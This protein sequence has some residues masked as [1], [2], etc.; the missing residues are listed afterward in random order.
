MLQTEYEVPDTAPCCCC[1]RL[2]TRLTR[3]VSRDDDAFAV[4]YAA[5]S[6]GHG[7]EVDAIISLGTW[8]A[9]EVPPDRVAFAVRISSTADAYNV[10]VTDAGESLWH[11][12]ALLGR[13]LSREDALAH[14]WIRDVFLV[15]DHMVTDDAPLIE[16]LDG[17]A[18]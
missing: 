4:Y 14:P 7:A 17:T 3:F 1:G 12:A 6:E 11:D 16:F 5:F 18:A 15:T 9:D 8:W 2:T 10:Q 13:K